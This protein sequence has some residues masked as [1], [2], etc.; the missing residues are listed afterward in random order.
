MP[1]VLVVDESPGVK[2]LIEAALEPRQVEV[3]SATSG[4]HALLQ[5]DR[6]RPDLVVCDVYMP[7]MDGYRICDFVKTH[8]Q[9]RATPV[10]L[11]ADIVDRTVLARAARVRSDDVA[12]K[13]VAPDDLLR[14]IA[15]LLP[16]A[17]VAEPSAELEDIALEGTDTADLK[18]FLDRLAG[19]P[20]VVLTVLVDR[21]GFLVE[22][23]GER[24]LD[25]EMVG[26]LASCLAESSEGI[27]RELGQGTLRSM[28]FEYDTGLVLLHGV[29]SEFRLAVVFRDP[30][31][32]GMVR[33]CIE[34]ARPA[35]PRPVTR[36]TP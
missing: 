11:M 35:M 18:T 6:E 36:S 2:M 5:I 24:V 29:G 14:R 15:R 16:E 30:A 25:A 10:L 33:R 8:P 13:P 22:S 28:I 12:S 19:E 34:R 23:A 17:S 1:K 9:L 32:L 21:Q 20:G 27:G 26:A 7:D 31:A 3:L 4:S